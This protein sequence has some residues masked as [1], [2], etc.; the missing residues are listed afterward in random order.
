MAEMEY[1]LVSGTSVLTDLWV[2]I[3]LAAFDDL[4]QTIPTYLLEIG[5]GVTTY[6]NDRRMGRWR[7][8]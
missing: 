6:W 1:A 4:Y 8:W 5:N 2:R 7:N 3:P